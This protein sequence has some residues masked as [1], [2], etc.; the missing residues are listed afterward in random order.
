LLCFWRTILLSKKRRVL[1]LLFFG[2]N[3][4]FRWMWFWFVLTFVT[5][6]YYSR[7]WIDNFCND[8]VKSVFEVRNGNCPF[9]IYF[10]FTIKNQLRVRLKFSV[11]PYL[12]LQQ[13]VLMPTAAVFAV[14]LYILL[15]ETSRVTVVWVGVVFTKLLPYLKYV[16]LK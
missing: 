9:E 5:C 12:H 13:V 14:L 7:V 6:F 10:T 11:D 2:I 16:I 3:T 8:N 1:C 15:P 4:V